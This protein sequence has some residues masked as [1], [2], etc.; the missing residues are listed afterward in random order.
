MIDIEKARKVL[1]EYIKKYDDTNPRIKLKKDH[2]LR[3]ADNSKLIAQKLNLSQEDIELAELIGLLHDI[4]RFEQI[5]IYNTFNDKQSIDHGLKGI[6]V[7][8]EQNLIRE[9]LGEKDYY[10]IIYLSIKNHNKKQIE[11]NLSKR[12]LLHA[13]IIRDAD[14]LDIF[15]IIVNGKIEDA[16]WFPAD[17]IEKEKI[18][19]DIY[20]QIIEDKYV[21]YANVKTNID[22]IVTWIAYAYD[23]NFK[24]SLETIKKEKYINKL[25]DRIDYKDKSTKTRM[26]ELR[27]KAN[28][29]INEILNKN[30][31]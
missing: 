8:F 7:L 23:L 14:K 31:G 29:F 12:E 2:I 1:N 6:E 9:F 27:D 20:K 22:C 19:D 25:V 4:G 28:E 11:E 16:V 24:V 21:N 18:S 5:R 13:R 15:N 10:K 26:Q 30:K 17:N 3:V